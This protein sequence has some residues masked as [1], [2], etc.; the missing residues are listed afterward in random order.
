MVHAPSKGFVG[1]NRKVTF[2]FPDMLGWAVKSNSIKSPA[3]TSAVAPLVDFCTS[4]GFELASYTLQFTEALSV[5]IAISFHFI[6]A[7]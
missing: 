4:N 1:M 5:V 7:P 6:F 2:T 3:T